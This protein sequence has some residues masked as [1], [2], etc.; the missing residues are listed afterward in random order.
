MMSLFHEI[1]PQNLACTV[2]M[3]GL[4]LATAFDFKYHRIPNLLNGCL[5]ILGLTYQAYTQGTLGVL[6]GLAAATLAFFIFFMLYLIGAMGAGD[7]KLIAGAAVFVSEP[8]AL[9]AALFSLVAG[10]L[11]GLGILL[12][13]GGL[14]QY[15][16]RYYFMLKTWVRTFQWVYQ[17]PAEDEVAAEKFPFAI[18][19]TVGFSIVL[20]QESLVPEPL[21]NQAMNSL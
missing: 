1:T 18:A 17:P 8:Q 21:L 3:A 19:I 5:F 20:L 11:L 16:K 10:S 6:H 7:V 15:L 4:L 2:L 12:V 9:N 13:K 14:P